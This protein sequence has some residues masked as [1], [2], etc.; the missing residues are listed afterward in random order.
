MRW[1]WDLALPTL[2]GRFRRAQG[3]NVAVVF[4]LAGLVLTGVV[5]GAVDYG[6]AVG[7]RSKLQAAL[8]AAVLAGAR[9]QGQ[10]TAEAKR[11]FS[12][13][14]SSLS[15]SAV[16]SSFVME[17]NKLIGTASADVPT[18]LL[19]VASIDDIEVDARA[20]AMINASQVCVLL[21]DPAAGEAFKANG[22]GEIDMPDCEMHVTSSARPATWID[23]RRIDSA[24]L[25]IKGTSGGNLRPLPDS[26]VENC[27]PM[28]DPFAGTF[29]ALPIDLGKET[30]CVTDFPD[31][32]ASVMVFEPGTY[33]NWPPINGHVKEVEFVPGNY[34]IKAPLS[35]NATLV[36]FGKGNYAFKGAGVTFNGSVHD[37]EMGAGF[38]AL[39][40]GARI[41]F[42]NQRVTGSGVTIY[43]AD[44]RAAFLTVQGA[45]KVNLT[46]P[47]GG[48]F[49]D[50]LLF[51]AAGLPSENSARYNLDGAL[52]VEGLIYLPSR[53]LHLNG[54]G[55]LDGDRLTLVLNK[56][57]LD[58]KIHIDE[59]ARSM[60]ADDARIYL[61]N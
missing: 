34:V 27:T 37:V 46:A 56:L 61:M 28:P 20:V 4:G 43:L 50:V 6:M 54:S 1:K 13:N 12:A 11:N 36:R 10:E 24:K 53:N 59:G 58:G 25:C 21:L 44:E 45:S 3:G 32:N 2:L 41:V 14:T 16:S 29:P 5:G 33:C 17:G 39:S 47:G 22:S 19:R 9:A 60:G 31:P 51:E 8:D 57:S 40:D 30:A 7:Q 35:L 55:K 38:Y 48:D 18:A 49:K 23:S 52:N 26:F 15:Y 42:N